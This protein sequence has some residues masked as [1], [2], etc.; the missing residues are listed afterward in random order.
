MNT[1]KSLSVNHISA[2]YDRKTVLND[3][4]LQFP[5]G[6][7]SV[8]M[9]ANACGKST[10]L[11]T[12]ARLI[13]PESGT[14][15]L[16]EEAIAAI[17]NRT[18]AKRL[19]YLP[20]APVVP[21]GIIVSDLV[22]RGRFPHQGFFQS[23]TKKDIQAVYQAM[24]MVGILDL[25]DKQV[26]ELS[27]GQLQRVW[28]A[29][30]IAQETDIL[31]L[32]EPTTYQDLTHQIEILDVLT[33]L[34]RIRQMTLIIVLHDINLSVRYGDYLIALKEG[35]LVREGKPAEIIDEDLVREVFDLECVIINDP[36]T[37][38]PHII[39]QGKHHHL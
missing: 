13:V 20:Q 14:I 27:G 38:T 36:I 39:P 9:G 10:L 30:A 12:I 17:P 6:K 35:R 19:G 3:L 33:D 28:I 5:P 24:E 31:L 2:G 21:E 8:I 7:I 26:D 32:D 23:W 1:N 11:K 4:S 25:A 15:T 29:M 18:Y 16:D 34:N 37:D 22:N